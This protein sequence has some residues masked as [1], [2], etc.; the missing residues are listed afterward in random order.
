MPTHEIKDPNKVS[1]GKLLFRDEPYPKEH[2]QASKDMLLEHDHTTEDDA[3][4]P[5]IVLTSHCMDSIYGNFIIL[6]YIVTYL[7]TLLEL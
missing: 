7:T 3:R 5:N 6:V 1:S 2:S 4:N